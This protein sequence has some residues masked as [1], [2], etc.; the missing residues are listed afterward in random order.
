MT[1]ASEDLF[2][3]IV[4]SNTSRLPYR[5]R[6][7]L[8]KL[9]GQLAVTWAYIA[10]AGAREYRKDYG[11]TRDNLFNSAD[12]LLT[13]AKLAQYYAEHVAALR[14]ADREIGGAQ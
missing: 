4:N 7:N 2:S 3:Y 6:V 8:A 1:A 12:V 10:S 13:A 14:Q 5:E 9:N 11:S